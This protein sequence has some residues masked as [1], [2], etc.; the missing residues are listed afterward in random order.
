MAR[1]AKNKKN[2]KRINKKTRK[3]NNV[4]FLVYQ[5]PQSLPKPTK[6]SKKSFIHNHKGFQTTGM[7]AFC[8]ACGSLLG[9]VIGTILGGIFGIF[10]GK[11]VKDEQHTINLIVPLTL[12]LYVLTV[13]YFITYGF[14][15]AKV[16]GIANYIFALLL[17][18]LFFAILPVLLNDIICSSKRK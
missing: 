18:M 14:G 15:I 11:C 16:I 13:W 6:N 10:L 7:A 5:H 17:I 8:A 9:G 4:K 3:K 12:L 2:N 1:R